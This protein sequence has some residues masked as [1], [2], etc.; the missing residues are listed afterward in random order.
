MP[1]GQRSTKEAKKP[2][3]DQPSK[4]VSSEPVMPTKVTVV[5]DR[6]KKK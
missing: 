2:K 1:K 5:P 6:S 3:K 4:P